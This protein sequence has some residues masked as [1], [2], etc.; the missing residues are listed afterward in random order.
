LTKNNA[1]KTNNDNPKGITYV[2]EID[3]TN[4]TS[5]CHSYRIFLTDESGLII[6]EPKAFHEG[7]INY[8]FHEKGPISGTRIAHM[9]QIS[10]STPNICSQALY[11]APDIQSN[12]YR[13]GATYLFHLSPMVS[14]VYSQYR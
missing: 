2:V 13:N 7:I 4:I 11:S 1:R 3:A 14:L 6:D 9:E 10:N 8:V 12:T 5:L